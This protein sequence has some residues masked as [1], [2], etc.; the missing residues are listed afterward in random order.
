MFERAS[1]T[2]LNESITR[3]WLPNEGLVG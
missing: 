2:Q 3:P 1:F